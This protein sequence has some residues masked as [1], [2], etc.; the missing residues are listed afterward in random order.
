MDESGLI[1][2]IFTPDF[3][4]G[5]DADPRP[6]IID[7]S[8]TREEFDRQF[9]IDQETGPYRQNGVTSSDEIVVLR[10]PRTMFAYFNNDRDYMRISFPAD[11]FESYENLSAFMNKIQGST[12]S[13]SSST[14]PSANDPERGPVP[15][16]RL[17]SPTMTLLPA[18]SGAEEA[19]NN[20]QG[21]RSEETF[22]PAGLLSGIMDFFNGIFLLFNG[23]PSNTTAPPEELTVSGGD[24]H[25]EKNI[26]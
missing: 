19:I 17:L 9:T 20:G 3:V 21:A 24:L 6:G 26:K 23:S 4:S 2:F 11:Q 15:E 10:M 12:D 8:M 1:T 14:T 18:Y 22:V 16:T 7:L 13:A 25:D 5:N